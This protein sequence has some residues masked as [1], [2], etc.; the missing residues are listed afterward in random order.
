MLLTNQQF[1]NMYNSALVMN[2]QLRAAGMNSELRVLD[3]PTALATSE[4]ETEGWNFF[5]TFWAT[6]AAQGGATT[7]RNLAD[8][9]NVYKPEGNAGPDDFN[10]AFA[11]IQSGATIEDRAAAF[12]DAQLIALDDVMA[13]PFGIMSNAQGVRSNVE[14]Y[15]AFYNIR[16]SNVSLEQ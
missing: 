13:I 6:T 4:Q 14:N 7:M 10:A 9:N 12:A 16:V 5:Y 15:Q 2:E 1:P 8:P 3:W 11:K